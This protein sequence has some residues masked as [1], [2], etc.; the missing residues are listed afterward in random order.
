[1]DKTDTS[2]KPDR[3]VN[4]MG[5]EAYSPRQIAD[6]VEAAGV[7][8]AALPLDKLAT[9]GVLAG[10][11]IGIGAALYTTVMTG[12]DLGF[13]PGRL[14]GGVAFSLGLVLVVIAGAELFTGNAL[15]V[16][17]WADGRV[18]LL[19][20][21]RNWLVTFLANGVG[22]AGLAVMIFLSGILA[23]GGQSE[24]IAGIASAKMALP[25][26]EAFV[27]GILCNML[28]CLAVWLSFAAHDVAGKIVAITFPIT[29]FV[30]LGFEHS[31]ANLYFIPLGLMAGAQ[32]SIAGMM[33]NLVPV[34]LGN[35][36]GGAGGVAMVYWI[37]YRR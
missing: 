18:S 16:M 8:K 37:I 12:N 35:I 7:V 17:A 4:V 32:G 9:L 21:L 29:A 22:A 33:M 24:T 19:S 10:V 30:A 5:I 14:L 15:I 1:M 34:T 27:R 23:L 13:G 25:F 36:V 3:S 6:R 28:V 31:I 26:G 11:F 20:L 2:P